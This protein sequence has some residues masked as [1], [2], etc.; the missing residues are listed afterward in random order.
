M[1]RPRGAAPPDANLGPT[2]ISETITARKLK[3]KIQL[4]TVQYLFM[5]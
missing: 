4:D 5:V 1:G 2:I 3:F